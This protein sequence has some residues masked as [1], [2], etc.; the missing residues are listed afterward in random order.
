MPRPLIPNRSAV[1]LDT[2]E[3]LIRTRGYDRTTVA[4][5][6]ER[7]GIAK[8]A[9]YREYPSKEAVLD[10]LLIRGLRR[11]IADV[12]TRVEQGAEPMGL[13]AV[14][15]YGIEA[16]RGEPLVHA[17][18]YGTTDVLGSY[19]RDRTDDRYAQRLAWVTDYVAELQ[20]AGAIRPDVDADAVGLALSAV[21]V[22]LLSVGPMVGGLEQRRLDGALDV[23]VELVGRGLD[24]P[25]GDTE[26]SDDT[27]ARTAQLRLLDRVETQLRTAEK[28]ST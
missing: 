22:G 7:A 26:D 13:A 10:A 3:E 5:I 11:L 19:A 1:I 25:A 16:L 28:G 4:D 27:E 18:L 17:F 9:M 15:R 20:R 6:A 8:G 24:R 21:T 23:I 2:A 14:Y 12:R